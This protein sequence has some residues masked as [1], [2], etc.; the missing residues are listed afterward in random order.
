[1]PEPPDCEQWDERREIFAYELLELLEDPG[2]E[3]FFGDEAG[4]EGDARPRQ[5][6]VKRASR[7]T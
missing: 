7:P 2:S 6:W 1:M 4:F 3:F 5:R